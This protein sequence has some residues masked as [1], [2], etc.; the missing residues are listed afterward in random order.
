[1]RSHG[2]SLVSPPGFPLSFLIAILLGPRS[3]DSTSHTLGLNWKAMEESSHGEKNKDGKRPA[4]SPSQ[5]LVMGSRPAVLQFPCVLLPWRDG[6]DF[7]ERNPT[8][9]AAEQNQTHGGKATCPRSR[10][11]AGGARICPAPSS[12]HRAQPRTLPRWFLG[13][14]A[15]L[16]ASKILQS[17]QLKHLGIFLL[18]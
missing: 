1:M 11:K 3:C 2:P 7:G 16:R 10:S 9:L 15:E 5:S 12:F 14:L 17:Q 18:L 8:L 13:L 4:G 6:K